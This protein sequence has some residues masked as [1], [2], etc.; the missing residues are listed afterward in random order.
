[1]LY[2]RLVDRGIYS[3]YSNHLMQVSIGIS[4]PKSFTLLRIMFAGAKHSGIRI[5]L[6]IPHK[7][8][9]DTKSQ[10]VGYCYKIAV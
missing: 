2:D 6:I 5:H 8:W 3:L 7:D 4:P 1:M 9:L 10:A